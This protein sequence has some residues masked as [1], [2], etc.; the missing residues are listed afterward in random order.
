MSSAPVWLLFDDDSPGVRWAAS[1]EPCGKAHEVSI[2][3]ENGCADVFWL[4]N[5][6]IPRAPADE[7]ELRRYAIDAL[8]TVLGRMERQNHRL[9][10]W[11]EG[12]LPKVGG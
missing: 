2:H 8:R 3:V 6:P 9:N 5:F 4:G 10:E 11:R 1:Y 12:A 7:A